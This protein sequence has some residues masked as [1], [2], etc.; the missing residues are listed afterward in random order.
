[1]SGLGQRQPAPPGVV[2][3]R[4]L[5]DALDADIVA[6]I[7]AASPDAIVAERSRGYRNRDEPGERVYLTVRVTR[8]AG[9]A[10]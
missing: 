3:V 9:G 10:S 5:G 7:I 6:A 4:L 1:M 2:R 8:P